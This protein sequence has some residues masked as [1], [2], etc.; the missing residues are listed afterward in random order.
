MSRLTT[1]T[2]STC[3]PGSVNSDPFSRCS[4]GLRKISNVL[5]LSRTSGM[6]SVRKSSWS[7][8]S[9]VRLLRR[10]AWIALWRL[11]FWGASSIGTSGARRFHRRKSAVSKVTA[12]MWAALI[13]RAYPSARSTAAS[14][15]VT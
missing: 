8:C 12:E 9:S 14:M 6:I 5:V 10:N 1:G 13:A 7:S 2:S 4:A 3:T 11:I 15:F